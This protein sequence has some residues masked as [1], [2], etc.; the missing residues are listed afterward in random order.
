[1]EEKIMIRLPDEFLDYAYY[2][3]KK[4]AEG[5]ESMGKDVD[6]S[7]RILPAVSIA[8]QND[9]GTITTNSKIIGCGFV[10]KREYLNEATNA[11]KELI[12]KEGMEAAS[13]TPFGRHEKA[14]KEEK[15]KV[16]KLQGKALKLFQK[17]LYFDRE[18]AEKRI[19]FTKLCT[20]ELGNQYPN[21]PAHMWNFAQNNKRATLLYFTPPVLS[22]E[23]RCNF[24][25]HTEG[26]YFDFT[27]AVHDAY[28]GEDP[29]ETDLPV[30]IFNVEEVYNNSASPKGFGIRMS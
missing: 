23:I 13:T 29:S 30:Y 26:P 19:D 17:Y 10:L 4:W 14:S 12:V 11:F 9:D 28:F 20:I 27:H 1:M 8:Q 16:R 3:R 6:R 18:E 2:W 7:K 25:I 15:E 24:E 22:Y 5:M 21:R